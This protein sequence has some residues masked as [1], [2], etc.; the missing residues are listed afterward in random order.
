VDREQS[1]SIPRP[2]FI[3]LSFFEPD[4]LLQSLESLD[5]IRDHVDDAPSGDHDNMPIRPPSMLH[6]PSCALPNPPD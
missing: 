4:S 6:L 1:L 2:F 5:R 3:I